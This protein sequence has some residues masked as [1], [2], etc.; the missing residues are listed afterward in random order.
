ML[1]IFK[2]VYRNYVLALFIIVTSCVNDD[3]VLTDDKEV[4]ITSST[5]IVALLNSLQSDVF[6][7]PENALCFSFQY[8]IVLGYNTSS[9][10]EITTF[11]GLVDVLSSQS[12]NFNITGLQ[13]PVEIILEGGTRI[14]VETERSFLDVFSACELTTFRENFEQ[15]YGQCFEL[16]TPI[17]LLEETGQEISFDSQDGFITFLDTLQSISSPNFK[18]P[19]GISVLPD[20]AF[21]EILTYYEFYEIMNT[22]S[23]CPNVSLG[24][25]QISGNV[26]IFSPDFEVEDDYEFI[27]SINGVVIAPALL[28]GNTLTKD[29]DGGSN[30]ICLTVITPDCLDGVEICEE[31]FV[32]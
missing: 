13:F 29:L 31:V 30:E 26:Y 32:P 1:N 25:E 10:I 20:V 28:V 24:I 5:S 27:Y 23:G 16:E 9:S 12:A 17:V 3:G 18:F 6:T 14:S 19:V 7:L 15:F 21:S 8:P 11:Q 2:I 4:D 22:C